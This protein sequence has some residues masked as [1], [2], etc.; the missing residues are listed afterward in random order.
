MPEPDEALERALRALREEYLAES[1]RRIAELWSALERVQNGD[2]AGLDQLR[3]LTHRLAGSGGGY[4]F[5]E[6]SRTAQ[7]ADILCRAAMEA[8]TM[9]AGAEFARLRELVRGV[10]DALASA[11]QPE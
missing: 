3:T 10:A 5:P 9:P 1:P 4:G 11:Q 2:P 7:H 8:G 6:I